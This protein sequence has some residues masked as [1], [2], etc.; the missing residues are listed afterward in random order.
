MICLTKRENGRYNIYDNYTDLAFWERRIRHEKIGKN[1][2]DH[3]VMRAGGYVAFRTL[4][5]RVQ[6]RVERMDNSARS[7]LRNRG[8]KNSFVQ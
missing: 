5:V 6:A 1:R 7:D 3:G 4:G 8:R 2:S